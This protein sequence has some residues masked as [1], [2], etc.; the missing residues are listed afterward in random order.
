MTLICRKLLASSTYAISGTLNALANRLETAAIEDNQ[1]RY[2][3]FA[4]TKSALDILVSA[5]HMARQRAIVET[6][7]LLR[8][9]LECGSTALHIS[10][11][12]EAYKN[13]K[14]GN[15]HS[16]KAISFAKRFI[17]ILGEVWGAF[18]ETAI[19]ANLIGFG[20]KFKS[21]DK[22]KITRVVTLEYGSRKLHPIQDKVVLTSISLVSSII[23]KITE[24]ILFEKHP[25]YEGALRL[26]GTETIYMSNS[27]AKIVKYDEELRSYP[28]QAHQNTQGGF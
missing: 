6:M 17:P 26:V 25:L 24:L 7:S 20:P 27:D 22:G 3:A 12:S 28:S 16:P 11:D 13:Y 9:A 23:L 21:N 14:R 8:V 1:A 19:H 2:D 5:L 10:Q 4:L 15:Y 18:S